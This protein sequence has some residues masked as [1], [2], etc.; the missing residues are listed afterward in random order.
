MSLYYYSSTLRVLRESGKRHG[1]GYVR[2][3]GCQELMKETDL[4]E[5]AASTAASASPSGCSSA[6]TPSSR[7]MHALTAA[8]SSGVEPPTCPRTAEPQAQPY[9]RPRRTS[10]EP[11]QPNRKPAAKACHASE[12]ICQAER[13]RQPERQTNSRVSHDSN[14]VCAE[15]TSRSDDS[16]H[17]ESTRTHTAAPAHEGTRAAQPQAVRC[18]D[19]G[20]GL[21]TSPHPVVS[22]VARIV[23][24]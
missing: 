12:Q 1:K 7:R 13:W 2:F 17:V 5:K 6:S 22:T 23:A 20:G 14:T 21:R 24:G 15:F 9:T 10:R 18:A 11:H 19:Y 3:G 16:T 8:A 4:E